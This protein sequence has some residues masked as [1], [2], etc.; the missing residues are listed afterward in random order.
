MQR[1]DLCLV[2]RVASV[3]SLPNLFDGRGQSAGLLNPLSAAPKSNGPAHSLVRP[4]STGMLFIQWAENVPDQCLC[5][6]L[7][8]ATDVISKLERRSKASR[9]EGAQPL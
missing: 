5:S 2:K 9:R 7:H 3:Y 6:F 8:W 4:V 1:S